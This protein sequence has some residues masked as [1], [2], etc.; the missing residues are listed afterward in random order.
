MNRR[1]LAYTILGFILFMIFYWFILSN[2]FIPEKPHI[3]D[4]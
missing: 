4:V 1:E 3:T 2:S